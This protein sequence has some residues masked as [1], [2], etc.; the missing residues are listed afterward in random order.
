ML[1]ELREEFREELL[2]DCILFVVTE[3]VGEGLQHDHTLVLTESAHLTLLVDEFKEE[4]WGVAE[5]DQASH[6]GANIV[7]EVDLDLADNLLFD[8]L[9]ADGARV[10]HLNSNVGRALGED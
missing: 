9:Q 7:A 2:L 5:A 1:L 6:H 3:V 8:L 10:G 4:N